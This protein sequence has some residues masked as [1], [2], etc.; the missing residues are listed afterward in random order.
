MTPLHRTLRPED[1]HAHLLRSSVELPDHEG[2]D[3]VF[4]LPTW[5]PGSYL[6]RDFGK[7]VYEV[8]A[9]ALDPSGSRLAVERVDKQT[10]TI[11]NGGRGFRLRYRVYAGEL[12]VRTSYVDDRFALLNGTSIFMY[13]VG[14]TGRG[15][16]LNVDAPE[17]WPIH[18]ALDPAPS[19]APSSAAQSLIESVSPTGKSPGPLLIAS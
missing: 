5:M 2:G 14:E 9:E 10:W 11:A 17:R 7:H 6:I 15:A 18:T 1:L 19:S 8:E 12:S 13:V 4:Y 16:T 3:L